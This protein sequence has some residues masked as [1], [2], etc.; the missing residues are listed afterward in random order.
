MSL[1]SFGR[2]ERKKKIDNRRQIDRKESAIF[3]L[4]VTCKSCLAPSA[5][6]RVANVTNPTGCQQQQQKKK[7]KNN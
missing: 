2:G 3:F 1:F 5:L 6:A 4:N 7:K